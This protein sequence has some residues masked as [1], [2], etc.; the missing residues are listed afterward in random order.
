MNE[1]EI[2]QAVGEDI[3]REF[4]IGCTYLKNGKC[5]SVARC[6]VAVDVKKVIEVVNKVVNK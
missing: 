3:A 6:H 5:S 1:I 2:K 4:C